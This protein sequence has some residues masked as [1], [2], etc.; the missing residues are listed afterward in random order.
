MTD[1][2][3]KIIA[4]HELGEEVVGVGGVATPFFPAACPE[5]LGALDGASHFDEVRH[6]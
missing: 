4:L 1:S 5:E 3:I 2:A 6:L